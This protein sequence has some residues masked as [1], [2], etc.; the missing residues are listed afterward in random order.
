MSKPTSQDIIDSGSYLEP[1]FDPS[2]LLVANLRAI[3]Q[4]HDIQFPTNATKV[5]LIKHFNEKIAPNAQELRREKKAADGI[6][7]DASDILDAESG[8]YLEVRRAWTLLTRLIADGNLPIFSLS[9][10]PPQNEL[11]GVPPGAWLPPVPMQAPFATQYA[12]WFKAATVLS[13]YASNK[14]RAKRRRTTITPKPEVV[15]DEDTKDEVRFML[16]RSH[17]GRY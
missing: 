17:R 5:V 7:S 3:L 10:S 1:F 14:S 8:E 2:T 4:H 12:T 9:Q 11:G 15:S 6:P 13:N 16:T